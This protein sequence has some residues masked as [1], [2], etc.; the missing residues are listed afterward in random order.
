MMSSH[1]RCRVRRELAVCLLRILNDWS[2][3]RFIP[4]ES[5]DIDHVRR[6]VPLAEFER[7][8]G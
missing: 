3:I 2:W 1:P 7:F 8:V 6:L 5:N 4:S